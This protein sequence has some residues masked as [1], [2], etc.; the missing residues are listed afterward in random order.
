MSL[1]QLHNFLR[2]NSQKWN[3]YVCT[4]LS[5]RY[6]LPN[7]SP[8]SFCQFTLPP[9]YR[10]P[11]IS[12]KSLKPWHCQSLSL[13]INFGERGNT[14]NLDISNKFPDNADAVI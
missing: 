6:A 9:T 11:H 1:A 4:F 14:K 8:E 2:I 13:F 7:S 5:V 10:K 12:L 3:C